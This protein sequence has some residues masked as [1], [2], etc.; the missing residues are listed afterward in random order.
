MATMRR[1]IGAAGLR[2]I[3]AYEPWS[4]RPYPHRR[5]HLAIGYGSR[6]RMDSPSPMTRTQAEMALEEDCALIALYLDATLP[7]D[8]PQHAFDAVASLCHDV[9]LLAFEESPLRAAIRGGDRD[10]A[11]D[12]WM[13]FDDRAFGRHPDGAT[14]RR[15]HAEKALFTGDTPG[16]DR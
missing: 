5:G 3:R 15:R 2:L 16:A 9:G 1:H 11:R 4:S 14:R 13:R 7:A 8:L 6:W 10:R 12:E